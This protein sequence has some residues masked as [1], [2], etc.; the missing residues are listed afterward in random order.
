MS[1]I[2]TAVQ[3]AEAALDVAKNYKTLYVMGCFGAP[4]SAANKR[5]YTTNH[6]YNKK[7]ERT[8]AINAASADTFGFDCV[9]LIK[10]LLWGWCGKK[11]SVYGGAT[12]ASNGVPDIGAN[13]MIKV[14]S[15]VSTDFS[16]I[17]V[18][19]AVWMTDHIGI[20]VGD[21]LAVETTSRWADGVQITAVHN[22][23]TKSG[24]NGRKWTK[25]GKLPY[26]TYAP[27]L[28][29][30]EEIAKEVL[31]C[32]EIDILVNMNDGCFNAI[33]YGCDLTYDY[34]KINGDYRT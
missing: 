32:D 22:I 3:L 15:D 30:L 18:G 1:K 27:V 9:C 7:P 5:R 21:G 2:E 17:Q 4:M 10:G 34:V 28:K 16:N 26:V 29:S 13:A 24:Y 31:L 33:A 11:T 25:H 19:E 12:Y 6:D 14:C 8:A 23:G 20:Y